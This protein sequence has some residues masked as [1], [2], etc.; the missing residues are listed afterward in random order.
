MIGGLLI[1][2]KKETITESQSY[3]CQNPSCGRVFTNP[4]KTEN[5]CSKNGEVYDAC[6]FCLTEITVE[7]SSTVFEEKQNQKTKKTGSEEAT[8]D[9]AEKT[10]AESSPKVQG[11]THYL[12]YLSER[13]K[14]EKIPEECMVCEN[15]VQCM[16]KK[17]TG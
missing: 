12:G 10:L 11:C 13:S 1:T 2:K 4:V 8:V 14:K 5:L 9:F 3:T 17:V 6:P 7:K 16:L 15:I